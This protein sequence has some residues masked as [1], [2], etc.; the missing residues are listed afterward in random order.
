MNLV[1]QFL[2]SKYEMPKSIDEGE[3]KKWIQCFDDV[4]SLIYLAGNIYVLY[5]LGREGTL[6]CLL[7]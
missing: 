2:S 4:T 7:H 5:N 1:L 6:G 3:R